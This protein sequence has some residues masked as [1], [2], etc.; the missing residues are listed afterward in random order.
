MNLQVAVHGGSAY[1]ACSRAGRGNILD[2]QITAD[3]ST[4]TDGDNSTI[5]RLNISGYRGPADR[6]RRQPALLWLTSFDEDEYGAQAG[7]SRD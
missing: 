6:Q 2:L 5:L 1:L 4:R 3:H 7:K